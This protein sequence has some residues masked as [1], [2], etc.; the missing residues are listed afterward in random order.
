MTSKKEAIAEKNMSMPI[1][2]IGKIGFIT[3]D[4]ERLR[5]GGLSNIKKAT[6][7]GT[8]SRTNKFTFKN[9][10]QFQINNTEPEIKLK[11]SLI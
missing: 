5:F 1:I 3:L 2:I 10:A 7:T 6:M 8:K 4:S 9:K 11:A